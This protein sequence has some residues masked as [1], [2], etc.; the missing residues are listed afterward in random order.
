MTAK[1]GAR[2]PYAKTP[3]VRQ[4]ILDVAIGVFAQTGYR[5]TTM[6]QIAQRA[7]ISESGLAH[8]FGT[9]EE[10]LTE[11]LAAYEAES[12]TQAWEESGTEAVR[13]ILDLVAKN[14]AR[15]GMV[16]LHSMISAEATSPEHP[17]HHHYADRYRGFRR[18]LTKAFDSAEMADGSTAEIEAEELAA[19]LI[20]LQDGLQ[21]QWLYERD[22]IDID[23]LLRKF[24]RAVAPGLRAATQ[25]TGS[26]SGPST[27][28]SAP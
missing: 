27:E 19:M 23:D 24:V 14:S 5:A 25:R 20:A 28:P 15:P 17:A 21:I 13:R 26:A 4:R 1:A 10:L 12:R 6:K 22:S 16:E 3:V 9:K 11:V 8:H 7:G 2:G 18:Y